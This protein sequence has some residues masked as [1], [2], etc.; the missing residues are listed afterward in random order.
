MIK[1]DEL[2]G[3]LKYDKTTGLFKWWTGAAAGYFDS[4]Y[5]Q[6]NIGNRNYKCHRLAWFYEYGEWPEQIDHINH[7][8]SDNRLSNLRNVTHSENMKNKSKYKCNKS[9]VTGVCYHKRTGKWQARINLNGKEVY[10]G[11]FKTIKEA[12][13]ARDGALILYGYHQNHGS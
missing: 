10:L 7:E 5:M 9:G 8:R 3:V 12:S 2:K 4:G 6:I 1:Q 13:S 11:L